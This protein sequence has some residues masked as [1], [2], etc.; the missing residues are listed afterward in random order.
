MQWQ[1]QAKWCWA[2]TAASIANHF[3]KGDSQGAVATSVLGFDAQDVRYKAKGNQPESLEKAL[4]SALG[5]DCLDPPVVS[6]AL[7]LT[8]VHSD[9]SKGK[10]PCARIRW[11]GTSKYHFV[12]LVDV[13]AASQAL[14]VADPEYGYSSLSFASFPSSYRP[15]APGGSHAWVNSYRTRP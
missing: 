5:V 8:T 13:D 6:N 1:A 12:T 4:D 9:L 7:S 2:A 3:G 15:C 11:Y 14:Q 10:P